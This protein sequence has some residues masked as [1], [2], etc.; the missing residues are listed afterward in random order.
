MGAGE[1]RAFDVGPLYVTGDRAV[2]ADG[3]RRQ[4]R[5]RLASPR[6]IALVLGSLCRSRECADPGQLVT[7]CERTPERRQKVTS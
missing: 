7:L 4:S 1:Q 2:R 3:I 5:R 6:N